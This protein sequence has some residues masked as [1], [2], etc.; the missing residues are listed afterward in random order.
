MIFSVLFSS[1]RGETRPL[2]NYLNRFTNTKHSMMILGNASKYS[3]WQDYFALFQWPRVRQ[4]KYL[5]SYRMTV[6]VHLNVGNPH[7]LKS[8][9]SGLLHI[10]PLFMICNREKGHPKVEKATLWIPALFN[11]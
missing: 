8:R 4:Q 5:M 11:S 10:S 2:K 1:V 7:R 3:V 6:L 9:L